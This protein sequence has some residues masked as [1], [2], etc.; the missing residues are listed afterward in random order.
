MNW[1]KQQ[2]V[3]YEVRMRGTPPSLG[4]AIKSKIERELALH[5]Q[6]IAH[7]SKQWPRWKYIRANPAAKSTIAEGCQ[8]F[9]IF[10]PGGRVLCVE[11][12]RTDGKLGDTQQIWAKEMEMLGHKVH[13][14][15]SMD[16]FLAIANS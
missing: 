11:C 10:L 15:R 3:D 9:T 16:E 8:D 5:D 12:K 13:V 14:V 2:F 4:R 6:I 7:C 1:T